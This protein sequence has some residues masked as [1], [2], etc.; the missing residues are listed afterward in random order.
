[1]SSSGGGGGGLSV[2]DVRDLLP[3]WIFWFEVEQLANQVREAG[4]PIRW[5]NKRIVQFLLGAI[6]AAVFGVVDYIELVWSTVTYAFVSAGQPLSGITSRLGV[7]LYVVILDIHAIVRNIAGFAGPLSPVLVLGTYAVVF[8]LVFLVLRAAAPAATDALGSIPV[9][10][11]ALD[12]ALTFMLRL[13][14]G[15]TAYVGGDG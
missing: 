10:G 9:V 4:G 14:G 6:G 7:D 13:W 15:L 11:S 1:M 5:V 8:Y 2:E 12:A 3:D